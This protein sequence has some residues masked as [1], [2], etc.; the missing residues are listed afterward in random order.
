MKQ[1]NEVLL[2]TV[3]VYGS[4][5]DVIV[6]NQLPEDCYG[7]SDVV[8]GK[9]WINVNQPDSQKEVTLLHEMIHIMWAAMGVCPQ[10][11]FPYT[12]QMINAVATELVRNGFVP[13]KLVVQNKKLQKAKKSTNKKKVTNDES[14]S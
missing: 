2:G 9:I 4:K 10:N 8:T 13:S 6:S 5:Y 7:R 12:E 11:N 14:N 3:S 1:A